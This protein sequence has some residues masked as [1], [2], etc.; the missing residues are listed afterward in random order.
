MLLATFCL[1]PRCCFSTELIRRMRR[2]T[3]ANHSCLMIKYAK[4]DRYSDDGVATHD[5]QISSAMLA[6]TLKQAKKE[7]FK[8][9][10]IG[11]DEGQFVRTHVHTIISGAPPFLT[12]T[13]PRAP[14][15][16]NIFVTILIGPS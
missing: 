4:D 9:G 11:I 10:V 2:F 3:V 6:T 16:P 1:F 8:H 12:I 13:F 14:P 15:P 5:R 7:A